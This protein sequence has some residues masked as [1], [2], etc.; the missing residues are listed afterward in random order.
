MNQ[1]ANLDW[2]WLIVSQNHNGH[3]MTH[4]HRH[5]INM[6]KWHNS[7]KAFVSNVGIVLQ[8][9]QLKHYHNVTK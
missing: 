9:N 7:I 3:T 5:D 4:R 6:R 2:Y 1:N 8:P